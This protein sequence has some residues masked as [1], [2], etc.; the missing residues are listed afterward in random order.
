MVMSRDQRLELL[1]LARQAKAD[2]KK[3][4]N[5]EEPVVKKTTRGR[6]KIEPVTENPTDDVME[7]DD[8]DKLIID[9][10]NTMKEIDILMEDKDIEE[11]DKKPKGAKKE[12]EPTKTLNLEMDDNQPDIIYETEY[13]KKPKKKIVKRIIYEDDSDDSV[14]EVII[15]NRKKKTE[16]KQMQ[17]EQVKP[18]S[19]PKPQPTPKQPEVKHPSFNFFNC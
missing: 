2:K 19:K 9:Y 10:N 15:D 13:R 4:N 5:T 6:K 8:T 17:R 7:Q 14:E 3:E 12:K 11:I 1:K 16:P 18:V